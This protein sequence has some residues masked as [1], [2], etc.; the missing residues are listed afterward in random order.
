MPTPKNEKMP[1]FDALGD[2][3][4]EYAGTSSDELISALELQAMS[5]REE[6]N[7]ED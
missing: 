6:A 2:L 4:A 5:L 7:A 1:F 3:L